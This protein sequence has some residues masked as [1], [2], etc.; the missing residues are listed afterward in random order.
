[1]QE[2]NEALC[3]PQRRNTR[4]AWSQAKQFGHQILTAKSETCPVIDRD[5]EEAVQLLVDRGELVRRLR[6]H[7]VR[8]LARIT[9]TKRDELQMRC[10]LATLDLR[11]EVELALLTMNRLQRSLPWEQRRAIVVFDEL[12]HAAL[13]QAMSSSLGDLLG[14]ICEQRLTK[15]APRFYSRL[16]WYSRLVGGEARRLPSAVKQ[17]G[18]DLVVV[19][20]SLE[21]EYQ[22]SLVRAVVY[23][24]ER[25]GRNVVVLEAGDRHGLRVDA[26]VQLYDRTLARKDVTGAIVVAG[27]M[28]LTEKETATLCRHIAGAHSRL[29]GAAPLPV[30]SIGV[31]VQGFASPRV[32]ISDGIRA[33][34]AHL[35]EA[36]GCRRIGVI[37]GPD[38]NVEEEERF[39]ACAAILA[40]FQIALPQTLVERGDYLRESGRAAMCALLQSEPPPQA[41]ITLNDA[42]ACGAR[43]ILGE[44]R[45]L[46]RVAIIG[47]DGTD[48]AYVTRLS[49]IRAPIREQGTLAVDLLV[50]RQ[51][52]A[53]YAQENEPL[54][55][56]FVLRGCLGKRSRC[57]ALSPNR[58]TAFASS[59]ESPQTHA[60][61]LVWEFAEGRDSETLQAVLDEE[62]GKG[63][64]PVLDAVR[65]FRGAVIDGSS[66]TLPR[67][68]S[69][70]AL[71]AEVMEQQASSEQRGSLLR[72][73]TLGQL[74][75]QLADASSVGEVCDSLRERLPTLSRTAFICSY[76][77]NNTAKVR[78]DS[79]C[80]D[81]QPVIVSRDLFNS[82]LFFPLTSR[83][84]TAP[85]ALLMH[86]LRSEG[87][88]IGYALFD[89]G[90][91]SQWP[92]FRE[93]SERLSQAFERLAC[94]ERLRMAEHE[95]ASLNRLA[96][97]LKSTLD[98]CA[99]LAKDALGADIVTIYP[100]FAKRVSVSGGGPAVAGKLSY[101]EKM[102]GA[103]SND[104][105]TR[106]LDHGES[107]YL[108]GSSRSDDAERVFALQD[109]G[110][111]P[112][113]HEREGILSVAGI[114]LRSDCGEVVGAMFVNYRRHIDV[115]RL[116]GS[117]NA[118]AEAAASA[119]HHAR[120]LQVAR[121]STRDAE[122]HREIAAAQPN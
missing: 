92:L 37:R 97:S 85:S 117:M 56:E 15:V 71:M 3:G 118:F 105:V 93:I 9:E 25:Y 112:G 21:G 1:M 42:M 11:H 35:V 68:V 80:V 115:R 109:H 86:A 81:G 36:H 66:A 95:L 8:F 108:N 90:S 74:S 61:R 65:E 94:G 13:M 75:Q 33:A 110:T 5:A 72:S 89:L 77:D 28:G 4:W 88:I 103:S 87:R 14:P 70:D 17:V 96:P 99:K 48:S 58:G 62:S 43:E 91:H 31:S 69:L 57:A 104:T 41:V 82:E 23:A 29:H 52:L 34:V 122:R 30:V 7:A 47:Y 113:F 16:W 120:L 50:D 106:L 100:R 20:D 119:I 83:S 73:R 51:R 79:A 116:K 63:L 54:K 40:E 102:K 59:L 64:Q 78:L 84:P 111:G 49:T 18:G 12:V 10:L 6:I 121:A 24:A 67:S 60:Q 2:F 46:D 39:R 76:V 101:P 107:V 55:T 26:I 32:E 44:R 38:G 19:I 27:A 114:V 45:L 53:S 22:V 98:H